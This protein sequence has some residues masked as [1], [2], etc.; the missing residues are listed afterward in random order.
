MLPNLNLFQKLPKWAYVPVLILLIMGAAGT[1]YL[2]RDYA[3]SNLNLL[4]LD[5]E[6]YASRKL[7]INVLIYIDVVAFLIAPVL[8]DPRLKW[9]RRQLIVLGFA[10]WLF[11]CATLYQSR[12]GIIISGDSQ[13]KT[14][15][16]HV[17]DMRE[18]L[19]GLRESAAGWRESAARLAA[20]DRIKASREDLKK[21]ADLEDEAKALSAKLLAAPAGNEVTEAG[22]WGGAAKYKAAAESLLISTGTLIFLELVGAIVRI[23]LERVA[24][25]VERAAATLSRPGN[26]AAK[27]GIARLLRGAL[28]AL[29]IGAAAATAT[30]GDAPVAPSA[31]QS[32]HVDDASQ[33]SAGGVNDDTPAPV[34]VD[35]PPPDA[36]VN[37]D[38]P[39]DAPAK[40]RKARV[41]RVRDASVTVMDS[42][43][44]PDDGTR[45]RRALAGVK[46]R[47]FKPSLDGLYA[48]VQASAPVARRYLAAMA[49]AGEIVPG[50]NGRGWVLAPKN[51]GA[52]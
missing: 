45:Y 40:A 49:A 5:A 6:S 38:T 37:V 25:D 30:A 17:T 47:Q 51:G 41:P 24:P 33:T 8:F 26:A 11:E 42:G 27:R 35:T 50:A 23:M 48:G 20:L 31:P 3:I 16:Q 19:K 2:T 15:L 52:A 29:G 32:Q 9:L 18:T 46:S 12:V 14:D 21:A 39:A 28:A 43:V 10:I 7:S 4:K 34:N 44:G 36:P 13:Q 1:I 22:T